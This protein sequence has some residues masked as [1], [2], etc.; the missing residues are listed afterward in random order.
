MEN[1][2]EVIRTSLRLPKALHDQLLK[3]AAGR[4]LTMHADI[5]NRLETSLG[6]VPT[7][8]GRYPSPTFRLPA[9]ARK[10]LPKELASQAFIQ[11]AVLDPEEGK[12][13]IVYSDGRWWR[14]SDGTA[15]TQG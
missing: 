11:L 13:H 5:I 2:P 14:Y 9:Y 8:S 1:E 6:T 7:A 10:D 15:V 12:A 4:G 3:A